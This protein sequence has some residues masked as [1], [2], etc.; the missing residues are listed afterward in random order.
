MLLTDAYRSQSDLVQEPNVAVAGS[1]VGR[2][3]PRIHIIQIDGSSYRLREIDGLL[4]QQSTLAP[5]QWRREDH[6]LKRGVQD[7]VSPKCVRTG[8]PWTRDG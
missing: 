5:Q 7:W 3:L 2:L 1:I 6:S 8:C 4:A